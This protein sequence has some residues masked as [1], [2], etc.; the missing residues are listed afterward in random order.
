MSSSHV[1]INWVRHV[2]KNTVTIRN[3][4]NSIWKYVQTVVIWLWNV[5]KKDTEFWYQF[6]FRSYN[7]P[8]K[9]IQK[10]PLPVL[11]IL[12]HMLSFCFEQNWMK[13]QK[14]QV[15]IVVC[16]DLSS[17]LKETHF[18]LLLPWLAPSNLF[19]LFALDQACWFGHMRNLNPQGQAWTMK[20]LKDLHWS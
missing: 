5:Q 6:L 17:G 9:I 7:T 2:L 11:I 3:A 12:F 1:T 14:V 20:L 10:I 19:L 15:F 4:Q 18:Y 16:S 13:R 8:S